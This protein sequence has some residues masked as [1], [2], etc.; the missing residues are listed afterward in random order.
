MNPRLMGII[1][2][3]D[4]ESKSSERMI[5]AIPSDKLGKKIHAKLRTAGELAMH[6]ADSVRDL[7]ATIE[8]GK[9]VMSEPMPVLASTAE[10]AA[11]YTSAAGRLLSE[12]KKFTDAQLNM[13]YPFEMGGK[14]VWE[15]TGF[16][17]L[18]GYICHEIHHRA[19]I[20]VVLRMLDAK[21]PGMYGPTADDM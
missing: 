21:V 20:G 13:K 6:M 17:L 12:A 7:T 2:W 11:N 19:Q 16:E 4:A 5:Q 9:L 14:I 15:P 10:L 1:H 18:S 3:Y 8:T